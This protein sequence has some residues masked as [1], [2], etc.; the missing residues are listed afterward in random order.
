[1]TKRQWVDGLLLLWVIWYDSSLYESLQLSGRQKCFIQRE[2]WMSS[3]NLFLPWP[4]LIFDKDLDVRYLLM[5][6]LSGATHRS[7]ITDTYKYYSQNCLRVIG[8]YPRRTPPYTTFAPL[9]HLS[10]FIL[11]STGWRKIFF[12]QQCTTHSNPLISQIGN[13]S[14]RDLLA[15]Y[16]KYTHRRTK[17]LLL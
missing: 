15:K 4:V 9:S 14:L 10:T 11:S 6:A 1:M 3:C 12:F 7:H 2:C 8:D 16:G 17:H 13:Y 5:P